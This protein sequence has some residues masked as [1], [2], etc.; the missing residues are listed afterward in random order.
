MEEHFMAGFR[1]ELEKI[2]AIL[3]P[4]KTRRMNKMVRDFLVKATK[5]EQT[6]KLRP[7]II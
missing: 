2:A 1:D 7:R 4:G 5:R 3:T 6:K